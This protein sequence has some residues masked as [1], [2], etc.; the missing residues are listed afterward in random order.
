MSWLDCEPH[1][2]HVFPDTDPS[3]QERQALWDAMAR[4]TSKETQP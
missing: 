4:L 2:T 3:P 1:T